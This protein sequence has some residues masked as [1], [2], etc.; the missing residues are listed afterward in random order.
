[1]I[2]DTPGLDVAPTPAPYAWQAPPGA[3]RYG[4]MLAG[5]RSRLKFFGKITP[6][7]FEPADAATKDT[8][9]P[10]DDTKQEA[11]ISRAG[12]AA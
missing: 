9:M 3:D 12:G 5:T 4:S 7:Q 6:T 8:A 2:A 11:E 1:M 10:C